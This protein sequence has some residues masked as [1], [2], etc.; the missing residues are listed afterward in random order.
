MKRVSNELKQLTRD[1]N[2]DIAAMGNNFLIVTPTGVKVDRRKI[3][4]AQ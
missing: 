2:G 4:G 1:I 3:R